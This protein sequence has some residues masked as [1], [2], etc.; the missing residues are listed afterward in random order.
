M[1]DRI[2]ASSLARQIGKIHKG[3]INKKDAAMTLASVYPE[4][5]RHVH[6]DVYHYRMKDD[7]T[8]GTYT[9]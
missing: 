3:D 1:G 2:K 5:L 9:V 7:E 6:I 4:L 8:S